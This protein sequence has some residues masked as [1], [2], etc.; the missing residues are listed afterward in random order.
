MQN[1]LCLEIILAVRQ[2]YEMN[3]PTL[4]C[5]SVAQ[6]QI[7]KFHHKLVI[8]KRQ[9]KPFLILSK[10]LGFVSHSASSVSQSLFIL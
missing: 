8:T 5:L 10:D 3:K 9:A 6:T 7:A 2:S 1:Q 4:F